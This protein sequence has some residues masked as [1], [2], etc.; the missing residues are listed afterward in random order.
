VS[1]GHWLA[2]EA[3][4]AKLRAPAP[5]PVSAPVSVSMSAPVSPLAMQVL[6]RACCVPVA[7]VRV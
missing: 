5:A 7:A 3:V 4:P 6:V 1:A 2:P